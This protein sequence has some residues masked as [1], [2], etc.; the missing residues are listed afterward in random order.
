MFTITADPRPLIQTLDALAERQLPFATM[1]AL[2]ETAELFQQSERKVMGQEFTIRRPWVQQQVKI[3]RQDFARKDKLSVRISISDK[4]SFLDKFEDG[5]MRTPHGGKSLVIPQAIRQNKTALIPASKRPKS[6]Q[7]HEVGGKALASHAKR[8]RNKKLRNAAL[9]GSVRVFE[10]KQ[11]TILIQSPN[12]AGV[13][14]QRQGRGQKAGLK[15]LY[16]LRPKTKVPADLHFHETAQKAFVAFWP[17][18]FTKWWNEAIRTARP[19]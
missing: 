16:L 2:N 8:F 15:V 1:K 7:F 6:F 19:A 5:G 9:G 13:I 12:G 11:R 14:L 10:G 3:E 4:A 17:N 18:A